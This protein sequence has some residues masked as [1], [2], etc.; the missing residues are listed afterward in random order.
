M[1]QGSAIDADNQ[2]VPVGEVAHVGD[3]VLREL[4]DEISEQCLRDATPLVPCT[5]HKV[6]RLLEGAEGTLPGDGTSITASLH[7]L[8]GVEADKTATC[9]RN[10]LAKKQADAETI[11]CTH[12][13]QGLAANR[14]A[15]HLE[16]CFLGK[17]R[18]RGRMQ[19][20]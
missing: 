16:R 7:T 20:S 12:C 17:G 18:K 4:V 14:F 10:E 11:A 3:A 2:V 13:G 1:R 19:G 15:P 9:S 5:S 6:R 8:L